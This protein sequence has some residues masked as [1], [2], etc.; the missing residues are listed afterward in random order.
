MKG[1]DTSITRLKM[2]S[3]ARAN[4]RRLFF[5]SVAAALL[6]C[7]G[8]APVDAAVIA[9]ARGGA[10]A[11]SSGGA[12]FTIFDEP[13]VNSAGDVVFEATLSNGNHGIYLLPSGGALTKIAE[14]GDSVGGATLSDDFDGPA[15]N[16]S[17][18]VFFVNR[19]TTG[20]FTAAAFAEPSGGSLAAIIKQGDPAPG[21]SGVF[22]SF[23]DMSVNPKKGD[24]AVIGSY[25][26]DGGTT[27]KVGIW[28]REL[29]NKKKGKTKLVPIVLSGD[30]LPGTGGG[31]VGIPGDPLDIFELD[32]PWVGDNRLVAFAVDTI[33]GGSG[34]EEGSIWARTPKGKI[35]P[36]VLMTDTPPAALGGSIDSL[37]VGRPGLVNN[38]IA[39]NM[40]IS[41]GS[42]SGAIVTKSLGKKKKA[43]VCVMNGQ[44]AP[45]TTGTFSDTDGV[46]S[47]TFNKLGDLEFHSEITGDATDF[48]GE[49]V[50]ETKG[51]TKGTITPVVLA[52]DAKPGGGSWS[53]TEEGSSSTKFITFLDD[54]DDSFDPSIVGVFRADMPTP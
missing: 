43:Q 2:S 24:F 33:S 13:M 27:F 15:I 16:D 48:I 44:S 5:V 9:I 38:V 29:I 26:E 22:V 37:G 46:S 11:P 10:T 40:E 30:T 53:N 21:T 28:L 39:V 6:V 49:F 54:N 17:G 52:G 7:T 47:P 32:G 50:C 31:V 45:G 51:K 14:E 20:T 1:I 36:F 23:D 25:T 35:Q 18:T 8:L 34:T 19:G 4:V 3:H 42:T 41:G 12:T